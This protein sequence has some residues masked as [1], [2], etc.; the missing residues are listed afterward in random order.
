[1]IF[2]PGLLCVPGSGATAEG[3]FVVLA[4]GRL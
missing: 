1:M 4:A 2:S 3:V